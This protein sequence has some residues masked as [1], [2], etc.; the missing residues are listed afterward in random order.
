MSRS[1]T[2]T[3]LWRAATP[4]WSAPASTRCFGRRWVYDACGDPVY[5]AALV[6]AIFTGTGQAEEFVESDGRLER[7]EPAMSVTGSGLHGVEVPVVQAV[8][9]VVDEDPTLIVTDSVELTVARI[10]DGNSRHAGATL[11]GRWTD[12]PTAVLLASVQPG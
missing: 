12:L 10:V 7:R 1:P 2:A 6:S 8:R 4:G 3:H 11:T 9:R 5:A